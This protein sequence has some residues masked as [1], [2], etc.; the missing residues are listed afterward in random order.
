M[1]T[2]QAE[3]TET[4][5]QAESHTDVLGLIKEYFNYE[6]QAERFARLVPGSDPQA[7][8]EQTDALYELL[9]K[10]DAVLNELTAYP[11]TS[12]KDAKRMMGFWLKL[13]MVEWSE[14]DMYPRDKIA[15]NIYKFFK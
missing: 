2:N 11:I 13:M 14:D 8:H 4:S 10:Q 1:N 5:V 7:D 15:M 12:D 6:Q 3:N 9:D